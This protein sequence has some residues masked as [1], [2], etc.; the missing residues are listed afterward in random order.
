MKNCII[1]QSGGPTVAINASLAGVIEESITAKAYD[2]V[3]GSLHGIMG[4]LN[5][6]LINLTEKV[7]EDPHFLDTLKITPAMYLGS[8]RF[9]MP[10][11]EEKPQVY[12]QIFTFFEEKE[13]TGFYY[14]GGNDSMDTV[15]Q[16]SAYA[17][18]HGKK[19]SIMGVPKTIDND[20]CHTD[21][22]PGF[23]SAAKYI[24]C[25]MS[26]IAYDTSIYPVPSVTIAEIM[27][28]DAG[29]L[30]AATALASTSYGL[31]VDLIYLPE[32]AFDR[33]Q[34]VADVT[35]VLKSKKNVLIAISEGIRDENNEYISAS[36]ATTDS[37]GHS[38][39]SGAG[40]ALE[41]LIADRLGIKVRSI[42]INLPQRCAAHLSSATDLAE[43]A[44]LGK[45]A[46]KKAMQCVTGHMSVIQRTANTPYT[47]TYD[48]ANIAEIANQVKNVPR[49]YINQAGNYVTEEM[50]TYL[51][52]LIAGEPKVEYKDGLPQFA[53][54]NH[55]Y[56]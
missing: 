10:S 5:N 43:S 55:L 14:I 16:L 42:E 1:A 21:H 25:T 52:P 33:N 39:L 7:E 48:T 54:L 50:L 9:K 12:E 24:A 19:V 6:D 15:L 2:T 53:P 36:T 51:R 27:G 34:F 46:V 32:V 3:Y 17:Q 20:L 41:Y 44:E 31:G 38:Q 37:F 23:G 49:S 26:E 40:K 29:W 11:A 30:T 4:V 45:I 8:C 22:T 47:V 18:S 13:I 56:K 35:S 28:R